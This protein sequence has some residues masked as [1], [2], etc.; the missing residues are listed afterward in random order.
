MQASTRLTN[1]TLVS[2]LYDSGIQ[3]LAPPACGHVVIVSPPPG[4]SFGSSFFAPVTGSN[5]DHN[6]LNAEIDRESVLARVGLDSVE[7]RL[8]AASGHQRFAVGRRLEQHSAK[9]PVVVPLIV[10]L[11]LEI[12]R[13]LAVSGFSAIVESV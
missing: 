2:G 11:V 3:F 4:I 8:L 12:P 13:Q 5:T 9:R 1:S 10:G 6:I 7:D